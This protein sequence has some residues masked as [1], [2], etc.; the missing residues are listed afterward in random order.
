MNILISY[1]LCGLITY[2]TLAVYE[3]YKSWP[4]EKR[5]IAKPWTILKWF[6]LTVI[7]WPWL[8]PLAIYEEVRND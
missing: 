5:S 3:I 7:L 1:L 8:L 6:T 4:I 2:I